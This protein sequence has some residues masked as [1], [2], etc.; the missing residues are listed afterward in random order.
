MMWSVNHVLD[1][2]DR[3][4]YGMS[5]VDRV[6]GLTTGT[7]RR[8]IDGYRRGG[9]VYS[10]VVREVSTGEEVVTWGEFV[11]ARLLAEFRDAGVAML[12]MRPA[13][14]RLREELNTRYPLASARTWLSSDGRE[15]VRRIQ[16]DVDLD[17]RLSLVVVRSGQEVLDWSEPARDFNASTEWE[18]SDGNQVIRRLRPVSDVQEVVLDPLV[19][20]GE[21]TLRGRGVR[22][23]VIAELVRAGDSTD[24]IAETYELG[25]EQVEAAVRYELMRATAV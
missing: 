12:R 17:R 1:L 20:F 10:P 6:L 13:V 11:E 2:L 4:V 19:A 7:A 9:R 21:P 3:P 18:P 22:T 5:T 23:E 24:S 25:R 16:D 8:W 14:E 15:L